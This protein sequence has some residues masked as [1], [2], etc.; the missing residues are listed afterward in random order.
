MFTTGRRG[1][2]I[3]EYTH[4]VSLGYSC[5]IALD[6][7]RF[8]LR[9][10][11][12]PFDWV[13]TN[14]FSKVIKLIE[15]DFLDFLDD[16]NI[17]QYRGLY[18]YYVNTKYDVHFFHDFDS[19]HSYYKQV[20]KIF[21]KYTRR[22]ER[23]YLSIKS[24][25]LFFRYIKDQEEY[26]YILENMENIL[27]VLKQHNNENDI[28]FICNDEIELKTLK[29]YKV[30]R[31]KNDPICRKPFDNNKDL[32]NFVSSD[33]INPEVRKRNIIFYNKK[34]RKEILKKIVF[35]KAFRKLS[36]F[37]IKPYIHDKTTDF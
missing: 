17:Y 18:N 11:S 20:D 9:T 24:P 15:D 7:E 28:I 6:L 33:L 5:N 16:K 36:F 23:F 31:D 25:T 3:K 10:Q 34:R 8:G 22:I 26:D 32:L 13:I 21:N 29:A 19:Y 4:A 27:K 37:L 35:Y 14:D 30:K 2:P 12:S 1:K